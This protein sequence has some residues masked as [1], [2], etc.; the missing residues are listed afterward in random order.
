MKKMPSFTI[1]VPAF[2]EEEMIAD[3]LR[4]IQQQDYDGDFE[5]IVV[6]NASTDRT[7]EIARS[8][9][10]TVVFE[11]KQGYVHALRAGF[12]AATGDIIACTDADTRVPSFWLKKIRENLSV[13]GNVAC[14]G[15]FMFYDG[16]LFIRFIGRVFGK[17]NYHLAGAN[18]AVWRKT[19]LASGGFDPHVNM[20]ADV[21]LGQRLHKFGRVVIDRSLV[22]RTSGR[23]FQYAF[24]QTLVLYYFNDLWLMLLR[25]PL[26]YNFPNIRTRGTHMARGARAARIALSSPRFAF[27]RVAIAGLALAF[28]LWISESTENRLFG[29]VLA[30]GQQNLPLVAITFDDGPSKYTPQILDTLAKYDVKATFF[31]IGNNVD[32]LPDVARRIVAEGH[33]IGNHTYSHPFWA[34]MEPPDRISREINKAEYSIFRATGQWPSYFRPPHGWR[35]PWM[36][37]LARKEKYTVVTWTISPD[38]WQRISRRTIEH[39][40]LSKCAAGSII[41]LHDGIELKQ[42]PQRQETAAALPVI[43]SELKS[44]GYRFVTIP[45]LI[46]SLDQSTPAGLAHYSTVS[47]PTE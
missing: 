9:G 3:C 11:R 26:F 33:A 6:N 30:H 14:S 44:R 36:M 16:P 4:S 12:G 27:A 39:R 24:F 42:E 43:I 37:Q 31:M 32:R 34:P 20:G 5:I 17:F 45:E 46:G 7:E 18:M 1:I 22:A 21:E 19:Y 38:D 29:T 47:T 10:A 35:S 2:N 40:V 15:V 23:R 25:R 13:Q 28:F 8:L 41:L